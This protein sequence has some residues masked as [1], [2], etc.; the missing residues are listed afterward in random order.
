MTPGENTYLPTLVFV[1]LMCGWKILA[2]EY[3][4]VPQ[5]I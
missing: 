1:K 3:R 2:H 5:G 4:S